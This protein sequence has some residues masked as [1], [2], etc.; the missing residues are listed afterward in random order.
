MNVYITGGSG[1]IGRYVQ[2]ALFRRGHG[3]SVL[4]KADAAIHLAWG[5]LPNYES[6]CHYGNLSDQY[7]MLDR[8]V[9]RGIPVTVAG[10]CLE[11]VPYA[12]HYACAKRAVFD[13]LRAHTD[14][15]AWA[16]LFYVYGGDGQRECSLL[17]RLRAAVAA[18][19]KTFSIAD[20]SRDFMHV[21]DV[22]DSL[23]RI[24]ESDYRGVLDCCTGDA[25]HIAAFCRS[26][27]KSGIE[28]VLDYPLKRYEPQM[29]VGNPR[30]LCLLNLNHVYAVAAQ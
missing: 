17:P 5:G 20:A 12:P 1:Y 3:V 23:V 13:W 18:G 26:Q 11:T 19:A 30:Q 8:I 4:E 29:L 15:F 7:E 28:Y 16:R 14:R 2:E 6:I 10:T 21:T 22:A 24:A 9:R 25:R 27:V